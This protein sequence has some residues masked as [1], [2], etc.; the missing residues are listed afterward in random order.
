MGS[1][2]TDDER[3]EA[4]FEDRFHEAL[5][6]AS[7]ENIVRPYLHEMTIACGVIDGENNLSWCDPKLR[8][9]INIDTI[10]DTV[11]ENVRSTGIAQHVLV[12]DTEERPLLLTYAI[13]K[14][15][16]KW[17]FSIPEDEI[18]MPGR[19]V[20]SAV[21]LGHLSDELDHA[22]RAL[23]LTNLEARIC[24]ALF[25]HGSTKQAAVHAGVTYN[26]ARKALAQA[27]AKM[28]ISRKTALVR[29]LAELATAS[30]PSR[31]DVGRILIDI[32]GLNDREAS[33]TLLLCEGHTRASAAKILGISNAVAKDHFAHIFERL[34]VNSAT[35]IPRLIMEAF[36]SA[37]LARPAAPSVLLS[38]RDKAPLRLFERADRSL[39]AVSDYGPPTGRPVLIVHSSLSTRHPFRKVVRGLQRAGFRPITID[40]P[41]F[42]LSDDIVTPSDPFDAGTDDIALVCNRLGFNKIDIL[43]RG[44]AF[45]VLAF[46][47]RFPELIGKAVIINPDLLQQQCSQRK[48]HL[49]VVRRAFDKY[50][51]RIEAITKWACQQLTP[52]RVET[53]IRMGI[54]NGAVDQQSF[55]DPEIMNDYSR[56]I[57]SF[58][59][60]RLSGI[61][62]EQRGYA[63]LMDVAGIS[64]A[65]NWVIV[66]GEI[67]PIHDPIEM[68]SFWRDKLPGARIE[69]IAGANRFVS[70]SHTEEVITLL[71]SPDV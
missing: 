44:G 50:P 45:H 60:G 43:T 39:V 70:L 71:A 18:S 65:D 26:T 6:A 8:A 29:K 19:V 23:G 25:T 12:E 46:A 3:F 1:A 10:N 16:E 58:S 62:R 4:E 53:I 38:R 30:A 33:L 28:N 48:G 41:G 64:R 36:A 21:S 63:T 13:A 67:D 49:G 52:K 56:S 37:M 57:L 11:C 7:S 69:R 61:I 35:D 24:T 54:G 27:M 55:K 9:W 42:G 59:T 32:F 66:V 5:A 20:I 68:I 22:A 34:G 14:T 17:P 51:D 40:R 15:A 2:L 47:R 31:E